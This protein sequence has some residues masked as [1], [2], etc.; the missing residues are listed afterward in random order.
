MTDA[1]ALA[2]CV[3][4][5]ATAHRPK[6]GYHRPTTSD[7][8]MNATPAATTTSTPAD[9]DFAAF[10]DWAID[11][12][13]EMEADRPRHTAGNLSWR[14]WAKTA[15][16]PNPAQTVSGEDFVLDSD[17]VLQKHD[18]ERLTHGALQEAALAEYKQALR[19]QEEH[20]IKE[21]ERRR[22]AKAHAMRATAAAAVA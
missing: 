20:K 13:L 14:H 22:Q 4:H 3:R 12:G 16:E 11:A 8:K 21:A 1:H 7:L 9:N 18:G 15:R 6:K 19:M 10:V 5:T 17:A 2:G